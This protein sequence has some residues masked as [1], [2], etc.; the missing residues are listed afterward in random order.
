MGDWK[1]L[2]AVKGDR[3]WCLHSHDGETIVYP[4]GFVAWFT[5]RAKALEAVAGVTFDAENEWLV[6]DDAA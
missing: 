5:S 2:K 1:P 3:G 4:D 6:Y